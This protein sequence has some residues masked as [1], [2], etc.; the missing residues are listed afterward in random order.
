M[1][2]TINDKAKLAA[3]ILLNVVNQILCHADKY[4]I[5]NDKITTL[6]K[7]FNYLEKYPDVNIE[8]YIDI[9]GNTHLPAGALDY[10]SFTID[11]TGFEIYNGFVSYDDGQCDESSWAKVFSTKDS[12]HRT[13]VVKALEVWAEGF[14]LHI[15]ENP[16]RSLLIIDRIL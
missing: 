12:E 8:G 2:D 7:V 5:T 1:T 9:S 6:A 15:D 16:K 4:G 11:S 13:N 14:L 10:A 3:N